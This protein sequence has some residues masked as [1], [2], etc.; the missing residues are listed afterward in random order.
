MDGNKMSLFSCRINRVGFSE[1]HFKEQDHSATI[2]V[3][4]SHHHILVRTAASLRTNAP[5]RG[6]LLEM[7]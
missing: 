6:I 3:A 2:L 7:H 5:I 1:I 4:C